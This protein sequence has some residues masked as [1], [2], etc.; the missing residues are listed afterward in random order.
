MAATFARE[1]AKIEEVYLRR[2]VAGGGQKYIRLPFNLVTHDD[3]NLYIEPVSS[4][5]G[6]FTWSDINTDATDAEFRIEDV[7]PAQG[8]TEIR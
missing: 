1:S 2:P 8:V 4:S 7:A 5:Q 3:G 6:N